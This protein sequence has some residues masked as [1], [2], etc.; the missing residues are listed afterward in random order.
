M[1]DAFLQKERISRRDS[2]FLTELVYGTLRWMIAID[3]FLSRFMKKELRSMDSWTRNILRL[4]AYQ[5]LYLDKVPPSAAVNESVELAKSHCNHGK[6]KFVNAVL[7]KIN[8][9]DYYKLISKYNDNHSFYI[10]IFTSHPM[11]LVE[12][13]ISRYGQDETARLCDASSKKAPL[14]IRVNS[15]K[16]DIDT[17][18]ES[19]E[20]DGVKVKSGKYL[21]EALILE[22]LPTSIYNLKSYSN[23]WFFIQDEAS[24]LI[25]HLLDPHSGEIVIDACAAPGGKATHIAAIMKNSGKVLAIDVHGKKLERLKETAIKMGIDIVETI[26]CDAE[27]IKAIAL[28]KCDRI[29]IDAPCSNLGV[30]RRNP[31][32]KNTREENDLQ[33]FRRLQE[34]IINGI[35]KLLK[36]NGVLVY[37]T[38]SFEPEE[39]EDLIDEFLKTH[40]DFIL[41]N[42]LDSLKSFPSKFI[43]DRGFFRSYP[44]IHGTDGFSA[45]RLRRI[46]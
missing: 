21:P 41:E 26:E 18:V 3:W 44:H 6:V 30:T 16:T 25:S 11:W 8:K 35:S 45:F 15:I 7:R 12:R 14:T 17:L 28:E 2:S 20:S 5:I 9:N 46:N 31:D 42:P 32:I 43:T 29:L 33:R 22:S 37:S 40:Q 24:M 36:T 4:G 19:L 39:N 27:N 38:C 13:W 1:I 34:G 23:G 10:H